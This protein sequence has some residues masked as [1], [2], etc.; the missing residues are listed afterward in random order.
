MRPVLIAI[1]VCLIGW[2]ALKDWTYSLL[3]GQSEA[4]TEVPD[5]AFEESWLARPETTPPGGWA[6]PWGVDLFVL[7]PPQS[8]PA[9]KG[10]QPVDSPKLAADYQRFSEA[11]GLG[12][13]IV[14]APAY[15]SPSP[16]S[17]GKQRSTEMEKA[18]AD[19]LS[20]LKRYLEASNRQRGLLILAAPDTEPLL[21]AVL[22]ALPEDEDFRER[23]AGVILPDRKTEETW[24][25][26]IGPCSPAFETCA[27]ETAFRANKP[28]LGFLLP[29]LPRPKLSYSGDP[30]FSETVDTRMQALSNWLDANAVKPAEPFNSWAADEV[31]DVAPIHRPN[32]D[33][34]ISGERGD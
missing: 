27:V 21:T 32:G 29:E 19:T 16:A 4:E 34:D 9:G 18:K 2:F 24:E 12:D 1:L 7:A 25:A 33:E 8:T 10:L 28:S 26:Q 13:K 14:Y 23:F 15:R 6:E 22:K 31:V 11:V 3:L 20:A 30:A 5:Y 17:R